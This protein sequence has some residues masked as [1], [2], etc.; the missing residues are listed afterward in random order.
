[1]EREEK[2]VVV[3]GWRELRSRMLLPSPSYPTKGIPDLP[4]T[5]LPTGVSPS[6]ISRPLNGMSK[7]GGKAR[8]GGGREREET[9]T[10][11]EGSFQEVL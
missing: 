1:M 5:A 10:V 9:N 6:F 8:S 7:E 11:P 4:S 2:E 3:V